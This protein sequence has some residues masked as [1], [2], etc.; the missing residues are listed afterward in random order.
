MPIAIPF[1]VGISFAGKDLVSDVA[2][3]KGP[4]PSKGWTAQVGEPWDIN[5]EVSSS[6]PGPV[7]L[8]FAIVL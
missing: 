7:K 8:V 4:L 6:I 1:Y 3:P 2:V 5:P